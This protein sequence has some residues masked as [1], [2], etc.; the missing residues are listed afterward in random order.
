[1]T[2]QERELPAIG[3]YCLCN[4]TAMCVHVLKDDQVLASI[5]CTD[6]QWCKIE[7]R[8]GGPVHQPYRGLGWCDRGWSQPLPLSQPSSR[9]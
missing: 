5:N 2:E 4:T 6:P 1:M 3:L 9:N 7:E 8:D